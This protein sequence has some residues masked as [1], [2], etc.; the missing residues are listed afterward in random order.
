[1]KTIKIST[2]MKSKLKLNPKSWI[3]RTTA[4]FLSSLSVIDLLKQEY[5]LGLSFGFAW[6]MILVLEKRIKKSESKKG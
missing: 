1:M 5:I 6:A 4:I 3:I 2:N